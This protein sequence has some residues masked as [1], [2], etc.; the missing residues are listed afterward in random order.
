M[1]ETNQAPTMGCHQRTSNE[2]DNGMNSKN[3]TRETG[4]RSEM[5]KIFLFDFTFWM[6]QSKWIA[7]RTIP[8]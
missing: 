5:G 2:N 1:Q 7:G 6:K 8:I 4:A 3:T